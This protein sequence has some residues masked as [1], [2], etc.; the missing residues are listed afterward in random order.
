M[1]GPPRQFDED[2]VVSAALHAFWH[3]GF[4][5]TK[6][7]TVL[8]EVGLGRQSLYNAFANKETLYVA[9]LTRYRHEV[10][11]AVCRLLRGDGSPLGRIERVFEGLALS[12]TEGDC[13]GCF[14]ANAIAE[15]G[16]S[17]AEILAQVQG[18]FHDLEGAFSHAIEEAQA[19]GEISE[20]VDAGDTARTLATLVE[21]IS[22]LNRV[23]DGPELAE[24]VKR[25]VYALLALK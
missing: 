16:K 23:Q 12:T 14:V 3:Q 25:S 11:G 8:N 9:A 19:V 22:L 7:S 18:T 13:P 21:G 17:N 24:S 6:L 1:P 4:D 2:A 15:F 20:V 10:I 5:R